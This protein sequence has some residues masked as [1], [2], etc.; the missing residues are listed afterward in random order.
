MTQLQTL[1]LRNTQRNLTNIPPQLDALVNLA[2]V[3]LSY[4]DL[5]SVPDAFYSLSSL[6]RLNLSNNC[7]TQLSAIGKGLCIGQSFLS[8][9]IVLC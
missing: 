1:H 3:D 9:S 6:K 8:F 4:N 5:E 7:I 2:D